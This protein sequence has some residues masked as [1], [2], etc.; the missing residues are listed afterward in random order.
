MNARAR[1]SGVE[2]LNFVP[3]ITRLSPLTRTRVLFLS[4]FLPLFSLLLSPS[5]LLS[6]SLVFLSSGV[7]PRLQL[8]PMGYL[9]IA[10][11]PAISLAYQPQFTLFSFPLSFRLTRHYISFF[12]VTTYGRTVYPVK[13]FS[14]HTMYTSRTQVGG[15]QFCQRSILITLFVCGNLSIFPLRAISFV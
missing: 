5:L 6:S 12:F 8:S 9:F 10:I 1:W 13:L 11:H 14:D 3:A 4:L 7:S 15:P 2:G